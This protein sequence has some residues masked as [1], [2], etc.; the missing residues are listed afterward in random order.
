MP[1]AANKAMVFSRRFMSESMQSKMNEKLYEDVPPEKRK[2][3]RGDM[4]N[5]HANR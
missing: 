4:E 1:G 3:E 2:R 5:K